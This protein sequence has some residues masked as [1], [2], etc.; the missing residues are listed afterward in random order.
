MQTQAALD[1]FKR[2]TQMTDSECA[3][4]RVLNTIKGHPATEVLVYPFSGWTLR[5]F[6]GEFDANLDFKFELVSPEGIIKHAYDDVTDFSRV[7]ENMFNDSELWP[8]DE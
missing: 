2:V 7:I 3:V 4:D 6:V 1:H 8:E 5:Y